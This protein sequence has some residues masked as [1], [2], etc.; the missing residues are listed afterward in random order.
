MSE[1]L[2]PWKP[3]PV[4]VV[5]V[6]TVCRGLSKHGP[7]PQLLH[8]LDKNY[9]KM[10]KNEASHDD[11][12]ITTVAFTTFVLFQLTCK[13]ERQK[14]LRL[15]IILQL[16]SCCLI[17][18]MLFYIYNFQWFYHKSNWPKCNYWPMYNLISFW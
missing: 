18:L 15:A 14:R 1:S 4:V 17:S 16:F 8:F 2:L 3:A 7:M 10:M 13:S 6:T 5:V 12:A 9:K 11:T